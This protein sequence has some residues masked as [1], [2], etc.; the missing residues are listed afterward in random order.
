MVENA[1]RF[2]TGWPSTVAAICRVDNAKLVHLD[3]QIT[4]GSKHCSTL[5]AFQSAI[6]QTHQ[7]PRSAGRNAAKRSNSR[8]LARRVSAASSGMIGSGFRVQKQRATRSHFCSPP[9]CFFRAARPWR[10][11]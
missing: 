9:C 6:A 7:P 5:F 4:S 8:R 1:S 3:E 2:S 11:S 10:R